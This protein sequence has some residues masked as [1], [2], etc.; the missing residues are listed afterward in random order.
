LRG[1][2]VAVVVAFHLG[3]LRGG[4]LGVDLFFVLS[5]FLITSLLL[6]EHHEAGAVGLGRFWARRARRLLP[7]LLLLLAGIAV[8]IGV[9]TPAGDRPTFRGDALA[10]LGYVANWEALADEADYW[11]MFTHAS[12][13]DHMWSLA[14][15]EQFY[16]AWPLVV[17]GALALA[18]RRGRSGPR[19]VA[20]VSLAGAAASF[21][22][23]AVTYSPLDTSR[24]YYGTDA[25]VGP[26]LLGAA[27]AAVATGRLRSRA[28]D[29]AG[30][31]AAGDDE[32]DDDGARGAES[33][34]AVGPGSLAGAA[35]V[36]ALAVMAWSL[37]ALDGVGPG[38]Y[39]GGLAAF[40]LAAVVLVWAVTGEG[41]G[42]LGRLLAVRPLAALGVIS[43][44]V[45]LW[46]WPVIVYLTPDRG[47]VDG[48][49]L[50]GLRIAATLAL[51]VG[52]Y[53]V[54]ERPIRRGVLRG[55]TVRVA[56]VGSLAVT[57]VAVVV[58]TAGV[59]RVPG[60]DIVQAS[61]EGNAVVLVPASIP[62]GTRRI[63]LV[64]DS[65]AIYLGPALADEAERVGTAVAATDARPWCTVLMPEG[66][67]RHPG[68]DIERRAPCHDQ[69]RGS[70]GAL[71]ADFDP[72]VV[73]YYLAAGGAASELR[74]DGEWRREC[75][76]AYDQ[77]LVDALVADVDVLAAEGATVVLATTPLSPAIGMSPRALA[78]LGCR[79]AIFDRVVAAR[80]GTGVVDMAAVVHAGLEEG[81]AM[82]R[83]PVH[84]S[85]EGAAVVAQW[86]V[87]ASLAATGG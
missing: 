34:R 31:D 62:E 87:P 69:R 84:L 37:A 7:A 41:P 75:E 59:A 8:L 45:Y 53:V 63:M 74:L 76:P 49:A 11:D 78:A 25:R 73:V 64:G 52:S 12:P 2:A 4:F 27:L 36:V 28:V 20:V 10:T 29:A 35:G 72:D 85:D 65:G 79:T 77:Y 66:V 1:L 48:W 57:T 71:A 80:P 40:A 51:A 44:G 81:T 9:L 22:V 61:G 82:F 60:T 32:G 67:A 47:R 26:T 21:A 43:Y 14:I 83:D 19:L 16:L 39:R 68:G 23:L 33:L 86:L 5:G 58:V 54:V 30:D 18:R 15:E 3:R 56:L 24:A 46:H 6:A 55:R 17:V 42:A 38:Y 70:W 50:D 13:L